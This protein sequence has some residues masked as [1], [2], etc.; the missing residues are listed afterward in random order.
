MEYAIPVWV[1]KTKLVIFGGD[2][3]EE[4]EVAINRSVIE[5]V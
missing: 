1:G 2:D 5:Q 4:V 3:N